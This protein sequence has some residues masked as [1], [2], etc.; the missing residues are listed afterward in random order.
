MRYRD[1][2]PAA[3]DAD[4]VASRIHIPQGGPVGDWVHWHEV[5]F[6]M[7]FC[8]RGRVS[9]A[10]EDQGP[11]IELRAGDCV[12]QPPQIRHRVL[13][14]DPDLEVVEITS[15][16]VHWTRADRELSL[17]NAALAP[18][19]TWSGQRFCLARAAGA[20]FGPA[21]QPGFRARDLGIFD[22]TA[23]RAD[24]QV[25][26]PSDAGGTAPLR[27]PAARGIH[28]V[29]AG[30]VDLRVAGGLPEHL[31]AGEARLV[32]AGAATTLADASPDL[33]LLSVR[34]A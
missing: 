15:P 2:L 22:A 7:I 18:A 30:S 21:A 6:Q 23:G 34:I 24:V 13:E 4:L 31:V 16:A 32:A 29:L 3:A 33:E 17:P 1:L 19:R 10:Y 9:V 5:A 8:W 25:V 11:P 14:C 26:R 12:L 28:V 27:L 20:V